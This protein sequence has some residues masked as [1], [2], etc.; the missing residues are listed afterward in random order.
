[1]LGDATKVTQDV[2]SRKG[3]I[4]VASNPQVRLI[5]QAK[6]R[7]AKWKDRAS[8][9]MTPKVNEKGKP[10]TPNASSTRLFHRVAAKKVGLKLLLSSF[11]LHVLTQII[12]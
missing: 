11:Y 4:K 3:N 7:T 12:T 6:G 10:Q 2:P 8:H 5:A 1:L 9:V